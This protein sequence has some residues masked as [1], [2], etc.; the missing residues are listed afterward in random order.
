MRCRRER[1]I[2]GRQS[3]MRWP[4][5]RAAVDDPCVVVGGRVEFIVAQRQPLVDGVSEGGGYDH[6]RPGGHQLADDGSPHDL[7]L[8][9]GEVHGETGSARW[10]GLGEEGTGE[11]EDVEAPTERDGC[12]VASGLAERDVGDGATA[13]EDGDATLPAAGEGGEGVHDVGA[14]GDLKHV[15]AHRVGALARD[16]D[17]RLGLVLG[18]SGAATWSATSPSASAIAAGFDAARRLLVVGAGL[19]ICGGGA[20][21]V[22]IGV[23]EVARG[24]EG[25]GGDGGRAD[26]GHRHAPC[27]PP[28][29]Q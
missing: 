7:S 8:S 19:V 18:P 22:K 16:D 13:A 6:H 5:Q 29:R 27:P 21:G 14:G 26:P 25:E 10:R 23:V 2:C 15:G 17:G 12:A 20:V 24:R 28:V 3:T 11:G 1:W 9:A 4:R